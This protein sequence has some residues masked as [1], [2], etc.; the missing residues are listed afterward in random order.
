MDFKEHPIFDRSQAK[1]WFDL[2]DD[3]VLLLTPQMRPFAKLLDVYLRQKEQLEEKVLERIMRHAKEDLASK[4]HVER[5]EVLF[6]PLGDHGFRV[7]FQFYFLERTDQAP[8]DSDFWWGIIFCPNVL[9]QRFDVAD[10]R[11]WNVVHFGWSV[12]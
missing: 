6:A 10:I 3:S 1:D 2:S 8:A 4:P 9:D 7:Y 5:N 11:H 12:Q